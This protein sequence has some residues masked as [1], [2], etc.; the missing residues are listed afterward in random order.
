MSD[1]EALP[2]VMAIVRGAFGRH[3]WTTQLRHQSRSH[4]VVV[5]SLAIYRSM[6]IF[7]MLLQWITHLFCISSML[8]PVVRIIVAMCCIWTDICCTQTQ[9]ITSC[10]KDTVS[11]SSLPAEQTT[12]AP[13]H[14]QYFPDAVNQIAPV[15]VWVCCLLW[16]FPV[17]LWTAKC[18]LPILLLWFVNVEQV[19]WLPQYFQPNYNYCH[20]CN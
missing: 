16:W 17:I 10:E 7:N 8:Y 15:L 9:S 3:A 18:H 5:L 13:V 6:G 4:K 12:S 14:P 19:I 20:N 11:L 2:V 1:G